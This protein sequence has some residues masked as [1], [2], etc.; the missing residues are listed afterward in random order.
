MHIGQKRK[1]ENPLQMPKWK[2]SRNR[3][4]RNPKLFELMKE[5]KYEE[6]KYEESKTCAVRSRDAR[7]ELRSG[8]RSRR[9][10]LSFAESL[11]GLNVN[12]RQSSSF[13]QKVPSFHG[14]EK[15]LVWASFERIG[16]RLILIGKIFSLKTEILRVY[17]NF[18]NFAMALP[19]IADW[20]VQ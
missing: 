2:E 3:R 13:E 18:I 7:S 17:I 10:K 11:V 1:P 4:N 8:S 20:K 15:L 19:M 6:G 9:H 12:N 14:E 16:D 5:C